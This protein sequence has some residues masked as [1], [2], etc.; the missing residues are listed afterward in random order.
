MSS[1]TLT[2]AGEEEP[3]II[4]YEAVAAYHGQSALAMLAI[5][6]QA[7]RAILPVLSPDGPPPRAALSITSGHPGPGVRDAFEF[8]T[9]AVT[10]N[11][12]VVDRS[13]PDARLN[14]QA[15]ISYSFVV[16]LGERRVRASLKEDVL[17]QRFFELLAIKEKTDAE[18]AE[19]SQLKRA[20]AA[21]VL[22]QEPVSLFV[23]S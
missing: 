16:S 21:R 4:G 5:T 10:R 13:L 22:A 15:D 1:P 20:I 7:L 3:I 18:R 23:L 12:Y 14:P 9:R 17:P 8:V 6:F 19:F 11:A 2:I